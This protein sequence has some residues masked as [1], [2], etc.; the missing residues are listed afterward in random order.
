MDFPVRICSEEE[1]SLTFNA[2]RICKQHLRLNYH[3]VKEIIYIFLTTFG[4]S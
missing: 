2:I 3:M 1:V 4:S